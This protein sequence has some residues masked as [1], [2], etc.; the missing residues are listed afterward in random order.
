MGELYVKYGERYNYGTYMVKD[1]KSIGK[2][3]KL[4]EHVGQPYMGNYGKL[5]ENMGT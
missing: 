1:W 3:G 5:W 4:W 2:M